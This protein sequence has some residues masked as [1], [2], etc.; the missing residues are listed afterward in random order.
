MKTPIVIS[1]GGSLVVPKTGIDVAFDPIASKFADQHR[2][3]VA[4][5]NGSNLK[6]LRLL[7]DGK[8][9]IGTKIG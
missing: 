2:L 5:V 4:I 8:K 6:N 1:V 7:I 9:W 3:S